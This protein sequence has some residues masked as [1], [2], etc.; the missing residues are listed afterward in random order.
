MVEVPLVEEP[1]VEEP[2]VEE[3]KAE[4]S[5][6]TLEEVLAQLRQAVTS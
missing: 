6:P 5:I 4:E 3:V 1:V 2:V